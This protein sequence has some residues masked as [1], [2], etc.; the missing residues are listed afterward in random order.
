MDA[1]TGTVVQQL[2]YDESGGVLSDSKPGFVPFGFAGGIWD[3]RIDLV[4]FGLRDYDASVGRW[5]IKDPIR[6]RSSQENLYLYCSG[7]PV[8]LVDPTGKFRLNRAIGMA[9]FQGAL[10]FISTWMN[11]GDVERSVVAAGIGMVSGF[12]GG[13]LEIER[14]YLSIVSSLIRGAGTN[15]TTQLAVNSPSSK[16]NE[17]SVALS[18]ITAFSSSALS[19]ANPSGLEETALMMTVFI[20]IQQVMINRAINLRQ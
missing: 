13:G 19:M 3:S 5:T 15:I 17:A 10:A 18:V 1:Q 12:M 20:S 2:D 8:N 16:L 9:Y 4:R 7:D 6:F 14:T 11:T